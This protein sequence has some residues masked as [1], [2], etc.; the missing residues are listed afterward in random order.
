MQCQ[1]IAALELNRLHRCEIRFLEPWRDLDQLRQLAGFLV[2]E[3]TRSGRSIVV[4]RNDEFVLRSIVRRD[5]DLIARQFL[6]KRLVH[7]LGFGIE[8]FSF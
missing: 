4:C 2:E 6:L 8:E 3:I 1:S 7:S 5:V